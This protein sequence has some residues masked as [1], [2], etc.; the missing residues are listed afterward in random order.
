MLAEAGNTK[1]KIL[2][3]ALTLFSQHGFQSVSIRD[4][5]KQVSIKESSLYYHFTNKRAILE[6]LNARF[7][8]KAGALMRRLETAVEG[9]QSAEA[10]AEEQISQI[11]FE[12]YLLDEFCNRYLRLLNIEQSGSEEMRQLYDDWLFA[13]P[14]QFQSKIFALLLGPGTA[15]PE[16]SEYWAVKYYAPVLLFCQRYL[17]SGALTAERKLLF[18]QKTGVHTRRFFKEMGESLW[19]T[20]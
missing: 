1:E 5:C 16:D 9:P 10:L 13:Q 15:S 18:Y 3:V 17:L 20:S 11:F 19:P 6:E 8:V 4:I 12:E 2:D 14:L 7:A